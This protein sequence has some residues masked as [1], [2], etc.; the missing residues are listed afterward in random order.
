[1]ILCQLMLVASSRQ[2]KVMVVSRPLKA[3]R[4]EAKS[5]LPNIHVSIDTAKVAKEYGGACIVF[6]LLGEERHM[7][8]VFCSN[9]SWTH[10]HKHAIKSDTLATNLRIAAATPIK[11]ENYRIM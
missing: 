3:A 5:K 4:F 10:F 9:E 8:G 7:L 1:M 6:T 11:R 2:F